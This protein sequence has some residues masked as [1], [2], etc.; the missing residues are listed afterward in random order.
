MPHMHYWYALLVP[1]SFYRT[2]MD[3]GRLEEYFI[4]VAEML[5]IPFILYNYPGAV[6]DIDI[7]SDFIIRIS[8]HT[9]IIGTKY[10][11]GNTGKLTRMALALNAITPRAHR[12]SYIAFGGMADF[13][14]RTGISGESGIIAGGADVIP[15]TCVKVWGLWAG[16]NIEDAME[17]QEAFSK[18]D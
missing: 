11:L 18:G 6:A 3:K 10:T 5:P 9:N 8:Q 14:F 1:P 13:T 16:G 7:D 15:R 17:L 12:S 2:A 4:N